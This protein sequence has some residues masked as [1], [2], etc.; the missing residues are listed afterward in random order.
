MNEL[1]EL[2]SPRLYLRRWRAQDLPALAALNADPEVMRY[3]P[4][5]LSR[6]QSDALAARLDSHF[7]EHGFTF[8]ALERKDDGSLIGFTG[9]ARVDFAAPFTP[10]VE[11]GWR[12]ARAHWA[13]GFAREAARAALACAFD[14]LQLDE[15][16]SFTTLGNRPSRRVMESIGM[17]RELAGDFEHPNLPPGHPL[18]R[19][20]L[21]RLRRADWH[22][23][24]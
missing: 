10:A 2:E 6:E 14:R 20:V 8:W 24:L 1:I 11:I 5:C 7:T 12:L 3:F 17:Q 15:V 18:R 4:T 19:H 23:A 9:L 21:Y 22:L 16:V 13:Q